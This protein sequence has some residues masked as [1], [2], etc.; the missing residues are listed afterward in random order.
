MPQP[1]TPAEARVADPI[2]TSVALG[3]RQ[4]SLMSRSLFPMANVGARGGKIISFGKGA[5]R[6]IDTRRS[7][8][9]TRA[10][11]DIRYDAGDYQLTQHA[12]DGKVPRE[13]LEEAMAV[14]G[15]DLQMRA[16]GEVSDIISLNIER[17]AAKIATSNTTYDVNNRTALAA[18]S[19]WSHADSDPQKDVKTARDQIRKGIGDIPNLLFVGW[20]VDEALRSHP[21]IIE[22]VKYTRGLDGAGSGGIITDADLAAYFRVERYVVASA[23]VA[24]GEIFESVWDKVAIVAY[25][26]TAPLSDGGSPSFGYTYELRG[27]PIVGPGWYDSKRDSWIYPYT[28]QATPVVAMKAAGYLISDVVA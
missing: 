27:Y 19:Q 22:Q 3:H 20:E 12:L 16:T 14:P 21:K 10:E 9:S 26:N 11:I 6:K 18:N 1:M 5:F 4:Q 23:T 13:M 7:P 28:E 2:L 17:D 24:N 8:G 15:I 25:T